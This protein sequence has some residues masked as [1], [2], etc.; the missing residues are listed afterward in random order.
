MV[1]V[2]EAII[3]KL[4]NEGFFIVFDDVIKFETLKELLKQKFDESE[5]FFNGVKLKTIIRG[6]TFFGEEF[7]EIKEII[8][9]KTG[10]D[11][12]IE[13]CIEEIE[14]SIEFGNLSERIGTFLE[15]YVND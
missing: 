3:F 7:E 11:D 8:K 13:D 15:D 1:S 14:D 9:E 10:F 5:E 4:T 12:I 2:K 6:R